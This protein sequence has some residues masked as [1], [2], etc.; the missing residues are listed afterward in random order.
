MTQ[1][2]ERIKN[3]VSEH[4]AKLHVFE[5]SQRKVWTI[6]G[7]GKEYWIDPER[8][9]C[10]CPGYYF[11]KVSGK[12]ECYH[13]EALKSAQKVNEIETISFV[14]EEYIDF[15]SSLLSDL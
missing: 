10:S 14:D 2:D 4:R 1:Q 8:N 12:K 5:P 9:F 7:T 3:I 15:I 6:V 11:G 13:L